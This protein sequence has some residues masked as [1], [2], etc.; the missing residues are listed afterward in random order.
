MVERIM[1]GP[2]DLDYQKVVKQKYD[3]LTKSVGARLE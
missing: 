3:A 1:V 2:I